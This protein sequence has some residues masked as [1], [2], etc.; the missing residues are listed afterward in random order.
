MHSPLCNHQ[1]LTTTSTHQMLYRKCAIIDLFRIVHVFV[2]FSLFENFPFLVL[3]ALTFG[4]LKCLLCV[5]RPK[6]R[7]HRYAVWS[8]FLSSPTATA[9]IRLAVLALPACL[10]PRASSGTASIFCESVCHQYNNDPRKHLVC[11][12][13]NIRPIELETME[14]FNNKWWFFSILFN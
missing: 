12:V 7:V 14:P 3:G 9:F 5:W 11:A 4:V 6:E 2:L 8:V 1:P 13:S 10:G